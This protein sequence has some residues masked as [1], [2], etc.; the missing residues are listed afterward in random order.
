MYRL[1]QR[2]A[3]RGR[4]LEEQTGPVQA[5]MTPLQIIWKFNDQTPDTGRSRSTYRHD[6]RFSFAS[7]PDVD[8]NDADAFGDVKYEKECPGN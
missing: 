4:L 8:E 5:P 2:A 1:H 6:P 7:L 3:R